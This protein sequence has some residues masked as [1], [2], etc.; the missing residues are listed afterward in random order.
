MKRGG[1]FVSHAR[2]HFAC[3]RCQGPQPQY[4]IPAI[5]EFF[6]QRHVVTSQVPAAFCRSLI[7]GDRRWSESPPDER[8]IVSTR[9]IIPAVLIYLA[10][11]AA[12]GAGAIA[13]ARRDIS[14]QDASVCAV[15][16]WDSGSYRCER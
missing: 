10:L 11:M 6:V 2:G 16:S 3:A 7:A 14:R 9:S 15:A 5:C 4:E 8:T 1:I 13:A 12:L